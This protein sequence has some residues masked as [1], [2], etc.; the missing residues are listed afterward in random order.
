[1]IVDD[2]AGFRG[3]AAALLGE[4][5]FKE[6]VE[7][8]TGS[9][10]LASVREE[11]PALVLL[12]VFLPDISG[13]QICRTLREEFGED[14][15]V[16]FV[17]GERVEPAGPGRGPP[18]GGGRLSRQAGRPRRAPGAPPA[19]DN[20]LAA[21][22]AGCDGAARVRPNG[23]RARDPRPPRPGPGADEIAEALVISPKTVASHVQ[24]ILAKLGVH[25]RAQ[26]VA[27]AYQLGIIDAPA[28]ERVDV[29]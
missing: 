8:T 19:G 29:S 27:A 24:R 25:S 1:L 2:D 14:L 13:F 10:A 26:A 28:R 17:S 12:D 9:E 16:I 15:P 23:A 22:A 20:S 4:A 18:R 3:F 21:C 5:G 11:R 7:A 6:T